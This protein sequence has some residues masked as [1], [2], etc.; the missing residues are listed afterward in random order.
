MTKGGAAEKMQIKVNDVLLAINGVDIGSTAQLIDLM[1]KWSILSVK[2]F[3]EGAAM[4]LQ[5]PLAF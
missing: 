3:R 1:T 5:V 4:T 2:V